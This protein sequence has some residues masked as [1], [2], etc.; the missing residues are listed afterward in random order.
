M[1]APS[2][3]ECLVNGARVCFDVYGGSNGGGV[4]EGAAPTPPPTLTVVLT[5]GGRGGRG[6]E[7]FVQIARG[8]GGMLGPQLRTC[9]RV[10]ALLRCL[11]SP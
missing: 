6:S 1:S 3:H 5:P 2:S 4:C 8:L 9:A 11:I 10:S 7:H